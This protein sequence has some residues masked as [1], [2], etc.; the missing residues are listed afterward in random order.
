MRPVWE[1]FEEKLY[2]YQPLIEAGAMQ[3][4]GH[5]FYLSANGVWLTDVVPPEYIRAASRREN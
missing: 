2:T 5:V 1:A 4:A 3:A